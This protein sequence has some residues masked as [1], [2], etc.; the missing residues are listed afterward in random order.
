MP[1]LSARSKEIFR[2]ETYLPNFSILSA[3]VFLSLALNGMFAPDVL[4]LAWGA[5]FS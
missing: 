5:A 2:Y 4:P 1:F 3:F